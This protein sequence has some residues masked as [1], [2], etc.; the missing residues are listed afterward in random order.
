M[1]YLDC[2]VLW[3]LSDPFAGLVE[4][5]TGSTWG[6]KEFLLQQE[7]QSFLLNRLKDDV[8]YRHR[9]HKSVS[10]SYYQKK[11]DHRITPSAIDL[12]VAQLADD[13]NLGRRISRDSTVMHVMYGDSKRR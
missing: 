6:S 1:Y 9:F 2:Y 13:R 3:H 12:G 11:S 7:F 4:V 5:G 8:F 10:G